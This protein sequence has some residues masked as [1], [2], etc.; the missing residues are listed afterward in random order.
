MTLTQQQAIDMLTQ[1]RD[2]GLDIKYIID[3][4]AYRLANADINTLIDTILT[5]EYNKYYLGLRTMLL[6]SHVGSKFDLLISIDN[7]A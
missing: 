5:D 4:H 6:A 3:G 2:L 1:Y 7:A